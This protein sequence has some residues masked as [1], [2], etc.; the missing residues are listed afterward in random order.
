MVIVVLGSQ[1]ELKRNL[2][3]VQDG[4]RFVV[5]I[6]RVLKNMIYIYVD[7]VLEK[8]QIPWGSKN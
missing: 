1:K 8:L 6:H 5:A 4:A 2:E 3:E 7:N